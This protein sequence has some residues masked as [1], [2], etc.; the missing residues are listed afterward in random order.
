MN[1]TPRQL[2]GLVLIGIG[3][4]L[5]MVTQTIPGVIATA[6]P[7]VAAVLSFL[8]LVGF[9]FVVLGIYRMATKEPGKQKK[10]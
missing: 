7:L 10:E 6:P 9:I 5:T 1:L 8:P 3:A 4:L 2:N